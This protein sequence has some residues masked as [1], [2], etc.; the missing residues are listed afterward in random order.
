MYHNWYA[1]YIGAKQAQNPIHSRADD[2]R[3]ADAARKNRKEEKKRIG[4]ARRHAPV[5]EQV[6]TL[7]LQQGCKGLVDEVRPLVFARLRATIT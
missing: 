7:L 5:G 4:I 1:L 2:G 3:L 6:P